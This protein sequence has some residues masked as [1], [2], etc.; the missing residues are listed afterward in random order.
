MRAETVVKAVALV[1]MFA[2]PGGCGS[3]GTAISGSSAASTGGGAGSSVTSSGSGSGSGAAAGSTGTST[4][5][6]A[7]GTSTGGGGTVGGA[8]STGGGLRGLGDKCTYNVNTGADT[9]TQFDLE[10]T[11]TVSWVYCEGLDYPC[12][13]D[14]SNR[15]GA[16]TCVLPEEIAPCD[17]S[18]GCQDAG[19]S[20]NG[21]SDDFVCAAGFP[22]G[23][24]CLYSCSQSTDCANISESCQNVGGTNICFYNYCDVN[25]EG[26]LVG[27]YFDAC[28]ASGSGDGECLAYGATATTGPFGAVC[29][30]NGTVAQGEVCQTYRTGGSNAQQCV[31]GDF[32]VPT[33][34]DQTVGVCMQLTDTGQFGGSHSHP[35]ADTTNLVWQDIIGADF[36]V[37][38]PACPNDGGACPANL[39]CR[40]IPG[41]GVRAVVALLSRRW[42]FARTGTTLRPMHAL[43]F[44]ASLA[45]TGATA[46]PE[47][48]MSLYDLSVN[49]L[50]GQSQPL[51]TYKGKVALVVN[52]A[53]ECGFTPQ[54][55]GLEKLYEDYKDKGFVLL[56][57]PSNDFGAQEPGDAKQ[58][59][60]FCSTKFHVTF[61][62]FEKVKTKGEG[63]SP[64]YG[65]LA[66]SKGEPKWNFHKYLVGKDGQVIEAFPSKVTPESPELRSAIDKA[67]K[68]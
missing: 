64:V 11:S 16:G 21:E 19:P 41:E 4:G 52:V 29:Y 36:A 38:V 26:Q 58:I 35:C 47:S 49:T 24:I 67:L 40:S 50:E 25:G 9:C 17:S 12:P 39:T 32:C 34:A 2:I 57:F 59:R 51:S 14:A 7:T 37:C 55:T 48:H 5:A 18:A 3:S 42:R 10:C 28:D 27:P 66:A 43:S 23:D 65:L 6:A 68:Q 62:M 22:G 1:L 30:Q 20:G 61:P 13:P 60:S 8:A 15:G 45:L 56:G 46:S 63:Q 53:S 54:Y 31:F 44:L 33:P